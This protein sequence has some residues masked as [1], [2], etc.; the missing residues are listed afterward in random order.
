MAQRNRLAVAIVQREVRDV[1]ADGAA[2]VR[3]GIRSP[4]GIRPEHHHG[5]KEDSKNI[6]T[7][8]QHSIRSQVSV[9]DQEV[10]DGAAGQNDRQISRR[11][12]TNTSVDHIIGDI[13]RK[14]TTNGS[15]F[16]YRFVSIRYG[17][18]VTCSIVPA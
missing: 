6:G 9:G 14:S 4:S 2:C 12:G 7:L 11:C 18:P 17:V 5:G 10:N 1:H 16:A 13:V 15:G 8:Q 3:R